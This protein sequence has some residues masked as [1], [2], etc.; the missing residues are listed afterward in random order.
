MRAVAEQPARVDS[1]PC[2]AGTAV[3]LQYL[4]Y[5]LV[6]EERDEDDLPTG[7]LWLGAGAPPSWF[8]P[9]RTFAGHDL[10]TALGPVSLRCETTATT[11]AYQVETVRPLPV[12][13]FYFDAAGRHRSHKALVAGAQ[14]LALAR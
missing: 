1:D 7:T 9:G 8:L 13:V 14:T 5:L 6:F 2:S 12:E 10:P 11:V 3:M 4:R